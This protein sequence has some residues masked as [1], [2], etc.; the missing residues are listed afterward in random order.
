L[1]TTIILKI[2]DKGHLVEIPGVAPFRTPAK[3]N[4]TTADIRNIIGHLKACGIEEYEIIASTDKGDKEV[5][6]QEDFEL[7]KKEVSKS[8]SENYKKQIDKR[9]NKLEKMIVNL[10][11]KKVS[12]PNN[13]KEQI[14]N[15]LEKLELIAQKILDEANVREV[16]YTK[17]PGKIDVDNIEE[18]EDAYIPEVDISDMKMVSTG[19]ET[20]KQDADDIEDAADILSNLTGKNRR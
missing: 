11:A 20:L 6:T 8:D 4:V 7:P 14:T 18:L 12:N 13:N 3:I 10:A 16:I 2:K 5:Y 9:F 17:I 19:V 1:S 15:K